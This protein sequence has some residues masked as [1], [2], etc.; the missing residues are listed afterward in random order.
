MRR[1]TAVGS[2]FVVLVMFATARAR[3]AAGGRIVWERDVDAA[4]TRA[5]SDQR[6]TLLYFT[7]DE[8]E[9]DRAFDRGALSDDGV[10]ALARD[11]VCVLVNGTG[12]SGFVRADA[13]ALPVMEKYGVGSFPTVVLIAADGTRA[14]GCVGACGPGVL[15][16]RMRQAKEPRGPSVRME[17]FEFV[18]RNASG[19]EEYRCVQDDAVMVLV[20]GGE[21][22][23]GEGDGGE[24]RL[25]VEPFLIDRTE[26]SNRQFDQFL[27]AT[28]GSR[29]EPPYGKE[30]LAKELA[31]TGVTWDQAAAYAK[32]CGKHLPSE[33]E[34]E[35]AAR[36]TDARPYPWGK[37]RQPWIYLCAQDPLTHEVNPPQPVG[38]TLW[39][40]SPYGVRDMGGNPGEWCA[41]AY[42]S[43]F[44]G[45]T[46]PNPV[47]RV[48][49]AA[50][51][52]TA[53][54]ECMCNRRIC[55]HE[56]YSRSRGDMSN[57]AF[58]ISFRCAVTVPE[59]GWIRPAPRD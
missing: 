32:W 35:K 11:F 50:G 58:S 56:V 12:S 41:D 17:G 25:R 9:P 15:T 38:S 36:G 24:C 6:P 55:P 19:Q 5:K 7:H 26:V 20:P 40:I 21:F 52:H 10:V 42:R 3:D 31:V 47:T 1:R 22:P 27:A 13:K 46:H 57:P 49:D 45:K 48:A 44:Y 8:S 14:G 39:D 59:R 16:E 4:T 33:A 37:D 43:D 29:S 18:G 2:L 28:K 54:S 34:W 30:W 51:G 23:A 53:R